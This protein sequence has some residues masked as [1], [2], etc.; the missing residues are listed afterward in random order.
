M[1]IYE[2]VCESCGRTIEVMQ[3]ISD[4]PLASCECQGQLRK[5]ISQ[6]CFH[7]KGSGWYVTDYKGK[8][9]G[10]QGGA[11]ESADSACAASTEKTKTES[12]SSDSTD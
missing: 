1:P 9:A 7:L 11:K 8:N 12:K 10:S 4:A 2:Y 6:S 3:K 5:L